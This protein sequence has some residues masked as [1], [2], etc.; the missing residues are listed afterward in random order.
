ME[1]KHRIRITPRDRVFQAWEDSMELVRNYESYAKEIREEPVSGMFRQFAE[2]EGQHASRL[3]ETL[4]QYENGAG[5]A[6]HQEH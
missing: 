2:D 3:L 1:Q 6:P 4:H 5:N